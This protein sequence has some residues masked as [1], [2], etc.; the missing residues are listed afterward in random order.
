MRRRLHESETFTADSAHTRDNETALRALGTLLRQYP[1]QVLKLF[2]FVILINVAFYLVLTY[3]PS[4]LAATLGHGV[5]ESN[6]ALVIIQLLMIAVIV[7]FGALS[8]RIGR[9][10]L[11]IAASAGFTLLSVPAVMLIQ[12]NTVWS[13]L[14]GIGILGLFLVMIISSISA[15]LPARDPAHR[16]RPATD[17]IHR[18]DTPRPD[19]RRSAAPA[20][21]GHPGLRRRALTR[22]E[23]SP[24]A[25]TGT[26]MSARAA[27]GLRV[28]AAVALRELLHDLQDDSAAGS[29]ES[30][31]G[32]IF[33]SPG[34]A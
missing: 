30:R 25:P 18:S 32:R 33:V 5:A 26:H 14:A 4:Y 28:H 15:T 27:G 3:M 19:R 24:A 20:R 17:D 11:L 6:F 9:K 2:G 22:R 29:H 21:R 23:A 1:A 8:D 13:Q 12:Q 7:P 31:V 34:A 10:P 16:P